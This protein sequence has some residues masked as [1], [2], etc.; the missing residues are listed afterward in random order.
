MTEPWAWGERADDL[1]SVAAWHLSDGDTALRH[2]HVALDL[3]P[4]DDRIAAN[5]VWLHEHP[6][7]ETTPPG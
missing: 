2:A 3:A 6:A 7:P 4:H 1:A 5:L